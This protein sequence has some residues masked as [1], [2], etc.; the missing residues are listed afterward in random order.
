MM[1]CQA[2]FD[3]LYRTQ[4]DTKQRSES[5][6]DSLND[7]TRREITEIRDRLQSWFERLPA[8]ARRDIRHRI[9]GDNDHARQ[10]VVFEL[11]IHELLVR[12]DCRVEVHPK[13]PST[14]SRPDFLVRHG[15]SAFYVEATVVDPKG[16]LSASRPL[17]DDVVA[18]INEMKSPHF[19]IFARVEG[20]LS[21]A[22][23]RRQVIEPFA[24]LL[25]NHDPDDVQGLIDRG[26]PNAA[27]SAKIECGTWSLHGWLV[28]LGL[29]H[30]GDGR[31]KTI[32]IGPARGGT[33]DSSTPV[34]RAIQK[35]A[36]KYGHLDA[37]LVVAVN[38]KDAFFDEDDET[39]ALFGKEQVIFTRD[40]PDLPV[41]LT[42][43]ADGVWIKGG[44]KPRYTRL[45]AVLMFRNIS[46]FN[47][48]KAPSCLYV[49]PNL[50]HTRLPDVLYRISHAIL[51][52]TEVSNEY[53]VRRFRRE[54]IGRLFGLG[55]AEK[56]GC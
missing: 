49:N 44:Y 18:K 35:K 52:E 31:P 33:I 43:K 53:E 40:R 45:A 12:L 34:Q 9:R 26:G 20:E 29:K 21:R 10:G 47:L 25:T 14:Q 4:G 24:S 51:A 17:E 6:L 1:S 55:E 32:V 23:S 36:K 22:L 41:K 13:I 19:C 46:P 15:N 28:P 48:C 56:L 27:P 7:S 54:N 8:E 38:A 50:E 2:L 5:M 30:R 39:Q 42:H 11:L 16:S 37:P 3:Q